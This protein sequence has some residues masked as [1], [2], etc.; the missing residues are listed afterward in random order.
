[1]DSLKIEVLVVGSGFGA[2][3]P[4]LRLSTAGFQVVMIEKGPDIVPKRDFEQTQDP[5]YLLR[6]IKSIR[7][8]NVNFTYAEG[9]G[10]GSGFYEM[11][12]LRA[13]SI[14]FDQTGRDGLRLWPA[15]ITRAA[16]DPYYRLAETM[17]H[18]CQIGKE[19]IPK[20][21][22]ALSYLL[23]R[24]G[25]T[26]DR[27]PYSVQGCLGQSYCVAGCIAGAK[28]TLH[29]TYLEPAV[30]AGMT[31]MAGWE[32]RE[33]RPL[34]IQDINE[35]STRSMHELPY[36]YEVLCLN[37]KT[38]APLRIQAKLLILGGGTVGTAALLLRSR[39]WLPALGSQLGKNI[40]INGTVKSLGI[41]P[42]GYP[43]GDM[44]TGRSHPGV[45]SYEFLK[46]RG[47]T[48]STAKPLPVDAVSY[49]NLVFEGETRSPATWGEAKVELM[50]LYRRRAVVLYALGLTTPTAELHL[51]HNGEVV[52]SFS[53]DGEFREYYDSTLDLLHSIVRRNNGRVV[54]I[55]IID[56]QGVEYPDL[57]ITTAH[58][59]GS[60]RMADSPNAGVVDATGGVFHYPGLYIA[61]GSAIPSSLAVNPY[62]T[63][64]ANAERLGEWLSRW[65]SRGKE[66][67]PDDLTPV[68]E[69]HPV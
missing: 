4:A 60:C 51:S 68:K 57:H 45:I 62:L 50:K 33:I 59:T 46:T 65:Y 27:V 66:A 24:L 21:G 44:F 64:L 53:L 48:I 10:G 12:S 54:N 29:S 18:V 55:R 34:E 38:N 11:V 7:G 15:G 31:I 35:H 37:S 16:M 42:E 52:P 13:P 69:E 2:A 67:V 40:A 28:V 17:M 14:A 39:R 5:Q 25:Y 30:R 6:Y 20:S 22:L 47:I 32:A 26:V 41:L 8:D 56:G 9:L 1:L 63:I 61:D 43:G 58:M 19:E 23:S 49:A 3:A 36:R